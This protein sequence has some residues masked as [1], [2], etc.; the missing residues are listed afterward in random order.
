MLHYALL[1]LVQRIGFR[2]SRVIKTV[3]ALSC[4]YNLYIYFTQ[5]FECE[6]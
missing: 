5:A 3:T 2:H 1:E 4:L 6:F